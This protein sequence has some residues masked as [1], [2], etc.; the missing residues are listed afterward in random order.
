MGKFGWNYPPGAANDPNAPYNQ[1]EDDVHCVYCGADLP[2]DVTDYS[3]LDEDA[4]M[5]GFC[6]ADCMDKFERHGVSE[7]WGKPH[8]DTPQE[9]RRKALHNA[10]YEWSRK[11]KPK[12]GKLSDLDDFLPA[13]D[14]NWE[15]SEAGDWDVYACGEKDCPVQWHLIAHGMNY[16]RVDGKLSIECWSVNMSDRELEGGWEE[17]EDFA[18]SDVA[19]H[20]GSE[21][22]NDHFRGWAE[23]WLD[24]AI[25]GDDPC[26]QIMKVVPPNKWIDFCLDAAADNVRYLTMKR[27]NILVRFWHRCRGWVRRLIWNLKNRGTN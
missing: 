27:A 9:E 12:P 25:T 18:S 3:Q 22:M 2:D 13:E 4:V 16:K 1:V 20:L 5:E 19:Y 26:D 24:A 8:W 14:F 15:D 21:P 6:N 23:Y 17:G 11:H 7:N 10:I